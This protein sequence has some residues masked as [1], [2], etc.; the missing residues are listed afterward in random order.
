M[1]L[2]VALLAT[3][4]GTAIVTE[5]VFDSRF[6]FV[7]ELN[8]MGADIR[9]EGRHAVIRGR[10]RL[11]GAPVRAL[12]VR[13]GAALVLAGLVAD[14]ETIVHE[15]HHVYRGYVDLVGKLRSVGA[16]VRYLPPEP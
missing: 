10:A 3:C 9:N 12:D 7:D 15:T 2:V 4:E 6:S 14:G 16:D 13:A 1:P 5:N 11:S 8:R